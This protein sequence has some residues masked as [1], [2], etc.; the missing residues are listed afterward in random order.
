VAEK[1][2]PYY[3]VIVEDAE[4]LSIDKANLTNIVDNDSMTDLRA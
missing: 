2:S 4:I 1:E 3:A